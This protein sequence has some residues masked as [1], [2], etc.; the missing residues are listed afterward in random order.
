M[1]IL[2][3]LL[4]AAV[5][6]LAAQTPQV[7]HKMEFAGITLTIRDDARRE[8]QKDVDALTQSPKHYAIKAERARSYFPIIEKIFSE[9]QLPNDFKY[10]AL[11][12]SA[13][14]AD[15]VSTSN[16][17]G[18]WQFKDFTAVE[19]GLRVDR[20]IDERL[21]IASSSRAAARYIKKNNTFF[22][23]WIYALQAYQMG[24]GGVMRSVKDTEGGAS[25]MEITSK[26]YWYVKKFLAHKVAY[27]PAVSAKGQVELIVYPNSSGKS[28]KQIAKEVG[29]DEAQ[30]IAY[31]KWT[32]SGDIPEDKT[33]VVAV[34]VLQAGTVAMPV[35]ASNDASEKTV[36]PAPTS[37]AVKVQAEKKRIN[38]V[39][40]IKAVQGETVASLAARADIDLSKFLKYNEMSA[41]QTLRPGDYYFLGKKRGRATENFHKVSAGEDL[42]QISQRYGVQLKRLQRFNRIKGSIVVPAGQTI[43]LASM[44]PQADNLATAVEQPVAVDNSETFNWTAS[45]NTEEPANDTVQIPASTVISTVSQEQV[46]QEPPPVTVVEE[47]QKT[48]TVETVEKVETVETTPVQEQIVETVQQQPVEIAEPLPVIKKSE[49]VVQAKETF[50][51]IA[52]M[53]NV[54]VMDLVQWNN[55]DLQQ[56][57][58]IGQVLKLSDSQPITKNSGNNISK[59]V[60]HEVKSSDTLYSI[61]RQYGVTIKDLMDWNAKKD[62]SLAVGEKLKIHQRQ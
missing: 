55:L 19:M 8:I 53:Y 26:T 36:K 17:V 1:R 54:R 52:N 16:A 18:F 62:F 9:E 50:Y 59:E 51:S 35:F 29:V 48:E 22:D 38:S 44:R 34:P 25:N 14:I 3:A 42:W 2:V 4:F 13:L 33:Y 20:H 61:A 12:E 30:L 56:G 58:K 39:W 46:S 60:L 31:N 6:P 5:Y 15:A 21:N 57:L 45:S 47:A 37:P 7:P 49:H 28:L 27:E 32:K 40:A 24:A 10:L 11:Q 23:N 43:F 41:S